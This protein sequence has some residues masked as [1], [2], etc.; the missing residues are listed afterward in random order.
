[1]ASCDGTSTAFSLMSTLL[2]VWTMGISRLRPGLRVPVYFPNVKT[3]RLSYSLTT[4]IPDKRSAMMKMMKGTTVM[5]DKV[6][7]KKI[8]VYRLQKSGVLLSVL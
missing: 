3:T 4:L 5:V 7:D 2:E 1:M 8:C 6:I